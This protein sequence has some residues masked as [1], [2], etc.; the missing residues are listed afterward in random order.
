MTENVRLEMDKI[1]SSDL[2]YQF[3]CNL[4]KEYPKA[5]HNFIYSQNGDG[6]LQYLMSRIHL[7]LQE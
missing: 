1:W 2:I 4:L 6:R 5:I 7:P 3:L